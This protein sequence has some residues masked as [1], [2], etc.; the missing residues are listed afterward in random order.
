MPPS[1]RTT[2]SSRSDSRPPANVLASQLTRTADGQQADDA[3]L[4]GLDELFE[5][6]RGHVDPPFE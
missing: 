3:A 1:P 2:S 4:Q 6:H 5:G